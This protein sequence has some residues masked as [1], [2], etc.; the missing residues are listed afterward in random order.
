[1][2]ERYL[3]YQARQAIYA[4]LQRLYQTPPDAN[5]LDWLIADRPFADFPVVLD[6]AG[7]EALRQVEQSVQD[8]TLTALQDDFYQLYQEPGHTAVSPWESVYRSEER[9]LFD[10][11][12]LQV[13]ETY[14]RHGMEFIHKNRAPE[15]SI[16]TELEFMK[17]LAGRLIQAV[18]SGDETA[19]HLL[20]EEQLDFLKQHLLVWTPQFIVQSQKHAVTPFYSG[21]AGVLGAYLVW[22]KRILEQLLQLVPEV[23][24]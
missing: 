1:M 9:L 22:E 20:L 10:V 7:A 15:D 24:S 12:T 3:L 23:S 21:L 11:H 17:I 8:A 13:R 19:E 5:L 4:L 16:A 18:D 6:E 14:A 2:D